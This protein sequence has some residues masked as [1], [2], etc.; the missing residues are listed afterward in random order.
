MLSVIDALTDM[1][2]ADIMEELP[3]SEDVKTA[4]MGHP[5]PLRGVY[6]TMLCYEMNGEELPFDHGYP[7]RV[8]VPGWS[9]KCSSK[10]ITKISVQEKE[11]EAHM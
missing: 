8:V 5:G 7:L 9:A 6:D 3:L 4:L 11:T 10:W 1:P 2:M